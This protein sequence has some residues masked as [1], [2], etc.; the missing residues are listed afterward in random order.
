[1]RAGLRAKD[2]AL[3]KNAIDG[4]NPAVRSKDPAWTYWYGRALKAEGQEAKAKESFELIADQYNF[5]G[6]LARE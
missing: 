5:Y 6:Q 4:M 3:V 1:V 2:W